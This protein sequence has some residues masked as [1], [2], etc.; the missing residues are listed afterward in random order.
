MSCFSIPLDVWL[1]ISSFLDLPSARALCISS[2]ANYMC[3]PAL[4]KRVLNLESDQEYH[5]LIRTLLS[6]FSNKGREKMG[7]LPTGLGFR[8]DLEEIIFE[9]QVNLFLSSSFLSIRHVMSLER[10]LMLDS[11]S[12]ETQSIRDVLSFP[13]C[14]SGNVVIT[15]RDFMSIVCKKDKPVHV[16]FRGYAHTLF[17]YSNQSL[18]IRFP[19]LREGEMYSWGFAER[20]AGLGKFENAP[21]LCD[22]VC[23][24]DD[25]E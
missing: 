23:A 17:V 18:Y 16:F 4:K 24:L 20:V 2:K 6:F 9:R 14:V 12:R 7:F 10:L 8:S 1:H 19:K 13:L 21:R 3:H 15:V 22:H 25:K 11:A 5:S